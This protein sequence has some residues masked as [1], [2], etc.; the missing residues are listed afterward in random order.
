MADYDNTNSGALF[1]NNKRRNENSPNYTGE[2]NV[3][4]PHCG[5]ATD[6][7]LSAWIKTMRGKTE[8][9]M[10]LAFTSKDEQKQNQKSEQKFDNDFDDD[11]PF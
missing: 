6:Y 5:C 8:K 3:V 4:C 9:F 1:K 2:S 11:I 7:W 10:S